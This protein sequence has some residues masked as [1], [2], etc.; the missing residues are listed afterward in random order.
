LGKKVVGLVFIFL[1][2]FCIG[3]PI[4]GVESYEKVI[5]QEVIQP[6]TKAFATGAE[7]YLLLKQNMEASTANVLMGKASWYGPGFDGKTT[8]SGQVYDQ[9]ALTAAHK[10]LAFGTKVRVTNLSNGES[11]LVTI[12]DRGPYVA[13]RHL[14]LSRA[15]AERVGMVEQGVANVKM[16][17][18]Q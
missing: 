3:G 10:E 9:N 15:A 5:Q 13:G 6:E 1:V 16:E 4:K 12:N 7:E 18:L 11:V 8:A 17:I 2:L 14:D